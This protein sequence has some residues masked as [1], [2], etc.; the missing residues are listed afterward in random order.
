VARGATWAVAVRELELSQRALWTPSTAR[1]SAIDLA[2]ERDGR[3]HGARCVTIALPDSR[4]QRRGCDQ[5]H[6]SFPHPEATRTSQPDAR[7]APPLARLC[8]RGSQSLLKIFGQSKSVSVDPDLIWFEALFRAYFSPMC[9]VAF[10][11]TSSRDVAEDVTQ[12]VLARVWTD[13]ARWQ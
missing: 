10:G 11:I 13:R 1:R 5:R 2:S 8:A 3:V 7:S 4:R 9:S 12:D 6:L